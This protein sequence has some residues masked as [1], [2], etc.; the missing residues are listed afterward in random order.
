MIEEA[1]GIGAMEEEDKTGR[2][3]KGERL[4]EGEDWEEWDGGIEMEWKQL[5]KKA[6][7]AVGR[8]TQTEEKC[9]QETKIRTGNTT[10][11]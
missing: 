9:G 8:E 6:E 11:C 1:A 2:R 7:A 4:T 10:C 5:P 3:G